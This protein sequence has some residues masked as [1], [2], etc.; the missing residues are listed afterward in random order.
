MSCDVV[1]IGGHPSGNSIVRYLLANG[2]A[3]LRLVNT[4]PRNHTTPRNTDLG[5]ELKKSNIPVYRE[6]DANT[7]VDEIENIRPDYIFVVGWSGLLGERLL[8]VP[9]NGVVGFHPSRLPRDRGRSVLAW[10]IAEGYQH[11]AVTM[12]YLTRRAD[13]GDI[14]GQESIMIGSSD[15]IRDVL[16][17]VDAAILNLFKKYFPMLLD[18]SGPRQAQ[19]ERAGSYRRLRTDRDSEIDWNNDV[20]TLYNLVRAVAPPYPGAFFWHKGERVTVTKSQIHETKKNDPASRRTTGDVGMVLKEL[21]NN[22]Y[23]VSCKDRNLIICVD[24]KLEVGSVL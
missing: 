4:Y 2:N 24:T 3:K 14:I 21:P 17:N 18:G 11:T 10:Q 7:L 9:K 6:I 12:F 23:I 5:R 16:I 1:F 19:D 13:E 15:Y 22:H 8:S 20:E